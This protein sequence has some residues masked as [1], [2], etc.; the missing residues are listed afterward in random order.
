[1][2]VG[3]LG[4]SLSMACLTIINPPA[5]TKPVPYESLESCAIHNTNTRASIGVPVFVFVFNSF[6][7]LGWLGMT[8][9]LPAELTLLPVRAASNGIATAFNWLFN[10][11]IVLV[12]PIAFAQIGY[13]TYIVFAVINLFTF[14]VLTYLVFPETAGRSLEEMN[15]TFSVP[16]KVDWPDVVRVA[17]R[18]PRRCDA[19]GHHVESVDTG[20]TDIVVPKSQEALDVENLVNTKEDGLK[21]DTRSVNNERL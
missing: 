9:L 17:R 1:M 6:F 7:A 18:T 2:L 21:L 20:K 19:Q 5:I 4:M 10:F 15:A 16:T 8:W 13:K 11:L 12:A 14:V 3:A